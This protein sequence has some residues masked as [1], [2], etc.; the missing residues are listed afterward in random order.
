MP[1]L[2]LSNRLK[3]ITECIYGAKA[4]ADIGT[5]DG[6][7]PVWLAL[8]RSTKIIIA[9]DSS[10]ESIEFARKTAAKYEVEDRIQFVVAPGLRGVGDA[11]IDTVVVAGVGGE[12]IVDILSGAPWLKT[13]PVKLVLQPQTK[14]DKLLEWLL[15]N[16]CTILSAK[17]ARDRG[18]DYIII[19]A[20]TEA[21]IPEK[22]PRKKAA[23]RVGV[24]TQGA[25]KTPQ[26]LFYEEKD[27]WN[28][29]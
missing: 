8:G 6:Y 7:I 16:G 13:R 9:S 26:N 23:E 15:W 28:A 18:R 22:K 4:V 5:G 3:T 29:T 21:I 24:A 27:N 11:P 20:S 12:T 1:R 2:R 25:I 17:H 19:V 10:E 14:S